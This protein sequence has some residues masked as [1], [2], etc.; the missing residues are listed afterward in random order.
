MGYRSGR[1]YTVDET[2]REY[3]ASNLTQI[4]EDRQC[5]GDK[6]EKTFFDCKRFLRSMYS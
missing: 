6:S 2:M 1:R 4:T 5:S 3:Q